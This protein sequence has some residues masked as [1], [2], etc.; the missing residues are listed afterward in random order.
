MKKPKKTNDAPPVLNTVLPAVLSRQLDD[1]VEKYSRII[2]G[3][4]TCGE[5]VN[6]VLNS[7]CTNWKNGDRFHYPSETSAWCIFRCKSCGE[8]IHDNFIG[9]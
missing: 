8:P 1:R 5:P 7:S 9:Q 6:K 3:K 2:E 4:C